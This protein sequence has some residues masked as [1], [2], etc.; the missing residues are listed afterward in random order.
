M[1]WI[2]RGWGIQGSG[3]ELAVAVTGTVVG[4]V[5]GAVTGTGTGTV[6]VIVTVAVAV[7]VTV[8]VAVL[9]AEAACARPQVAVFDLGSSAPGWTGQAMRKVVPRPGSV[10]RASDA[11]WP[12]TMP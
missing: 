3:F 4:A 10:L 1:H 7:L 11:P 5:T 2:G 6:A 8:A 9:V 12:W